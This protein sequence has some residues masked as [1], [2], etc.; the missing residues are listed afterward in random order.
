M[1]FDATQA[2]LTDSFGRQ[3]TYLRV[4]VTDRCDLRC[5]YCLP[6][7]ARFLPRKELLSLE[8]IARLSEAFMDLGVRK[9]RITGGEPLIRRDILSLFR[10]L[11]PAL[12]AGRL[13]E[14]TLTTNG[15]QLARFASD[16]AALGVARVNV[17]LDSLSPC[18]YR[19]ITRTGTL[20]KVMKGLEAAQS[21]GL[22]VKLNAL[23]SRGP[24]EEEIDD[25]IRFAHGHGM[26]LTL[27]EE[28]PLGRTG[29]DRSQTFLSIGALRR[30]LSRRWTLKENDHNSGGPA[31]YVTVA[32][33][34]GRIGFITAMSCSF[35]DSCNRVRLSS[36]GRLFTCMAQYGSVDL[37]PGLKGGRHALPDLVREAV[38]AK[39]ARHD[40][41]D[42]PADLGRT[43]S[44][45]GG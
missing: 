44:S 36:T 12:D 25:L 45:L 3:V 29:T 10:Q 24:F 22:K 14:L 40:F 1:P 19:Q 21:A 42:G 23:A 32:E 34:G 39:P 33:T 4:S 16:L 6:E 9:I 38:L 30:A 41:H 11:S 17:S 20:D 35:C 43:M 31:R 5:T 13:E 26:D 37:R 28:M 27:I 7:R 8:E 18:R 15:S 2:P